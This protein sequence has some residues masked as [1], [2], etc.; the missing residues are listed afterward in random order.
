MI[1]SHDCDDNIK[2][3]SC[4]V[5]RIEFEST[6]ERFELNDIDVINVVVIDSEGDE[7][8]EVLPAMDAAMN[9]VF[10]EKYDYFMD[11]L[12]GY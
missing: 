6:P 7:V 3:G 11:Q 8:C 4:Y 2:I 10:D 12:C 9:Y 1:I 5:S